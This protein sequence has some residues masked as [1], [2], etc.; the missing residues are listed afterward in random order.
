MFS[1]VASAFALA[2]GSHQGENEMSGLLVNPLIDRLMANRESRVFD[3]QSSG[4]KFR[5][6]FEA[7]SFFDI[8]PDRV[9]FESLA[10][11]GFVLAFIGSLLS[12]VSQVI[13]G[14]N[15]RGISFKLP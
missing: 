9:V 10:S 13:S 1:G 11:M 3:G 6:P 5:R 14:I 4:D 12:F 8:T 7:K 2:M 15:R